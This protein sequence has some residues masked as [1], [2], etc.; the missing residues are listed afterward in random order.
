VAKVNSSLSAS[1]AGV[2]LIQLPITRILSLLANR[3]CLCSIAATTHVICLG[4]CV[5]SLLLITD[6]YKDTLRYGAKSICH[7]FHFSIHR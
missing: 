7:R 4:G 1:A 2:G 6:T 5:L 3:N